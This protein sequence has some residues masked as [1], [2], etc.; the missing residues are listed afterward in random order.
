M[1]AIEIKDS[2]GNRLVT[3]SDSI[4]Q[5]ALTTS[6]AGVILSGNT[7]A[8][9]ING[10]AT[11][12]GLKLEAPS[13]QASV[14][15]VFTIVG[16]AINVTSAAFTYA[17]PPIE[18]ISIITQP[19]AGIFVSGSSIA[20]ITQPAIKVMDIYGRAI[21]TDDSS[22]DAGIVSAITTSAL[23]LGGTMNRTAVAGAVTFNDLTLNM[24]TTA[25][26]IVLRFSLS[27][28]PLIYKDSI[29]FDYD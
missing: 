23:T 22:I 5:A 1:P 3:D 27:S 24:N 20:L 29:L 8:A 10:I 7:T 19:V 11:F 9:A 2:F 13:D 16:K 6:V 4:I 14:Q 21:E 17:I 26:S 15:L 25:G 18:G 28:D 12:S